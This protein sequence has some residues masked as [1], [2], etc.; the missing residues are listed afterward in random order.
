M[1]SRK[2]QPSRSGAGTRPKTSSQSGPRSAKKAVPPQETVDGTIGDAVSETVI[3]VSATAAPD[4]ATEKD[5]AQK[6]PKAGGDRLIMAGLGLGI[7]LSLGL[8]GAAF[9]SE[10]RRSDP[11]KI[12]APLQ[13]QISQLEAEIASARDAGAQNVSRSDLDTLAAGLAE[14][15]SQLA[16]SIDTLQQQ[17]A[18][19]APD[20]SPVISRIDALETRMD[21]LAASMAAVAAEIKPAAAT[22]APASPPPESEASTETSDSMDNDGWGAFF[23]DFFKIT[24][25]DDEAK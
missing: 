17:T 10:A 13:A 12:I 2:K 11:A 18:P 15:M 25:I 21:D 6:T 9:M 4:P 7:M 23:S 3:E 22:T 16:A 1:A 5:A 14:E 20:L 24:R 19:A 8:A